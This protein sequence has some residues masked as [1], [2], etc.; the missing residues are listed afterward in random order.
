MIITLGSLQFDMPDKLGTWYRAEV[1]ERLFA[2]V[3]E[4]RF[5][6]MLIDTGIKLMEHE[7]KHQGVPKDAL[8]DKLLT[9]SYE[10]ILSQYALVHPNTYKE[11]ILGTLLTSFGDYT[12]I[13]GMKQAEDAEVQSVIDFF[14]ASAQSRT[15]G[16]TSAPS[17]GRASKARVPR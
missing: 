16:V 14:S 7:R 5:A 9:E 17:T 15:A 11:V 6:S 13:D 8:Q 4:S 1:A 3:L 10:Q 2:A 12:V